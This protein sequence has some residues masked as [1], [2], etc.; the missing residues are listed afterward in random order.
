MQEVIGT[1]SKRLIANNLDILALATV[2]G[3]TENMRNHAFLGVTCHTSQDGQ[4]EI[5]YRM[6][7][8]I[9]RQIDGSPFAITGGVAFD[10]VYRI[11]RDEYRVTFTDTSGVANNVDLGTLRTNVN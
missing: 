1:D 8:G 11:T 9:W 5:E 3:P 4:L 2:A 7:G 6:P 10:R